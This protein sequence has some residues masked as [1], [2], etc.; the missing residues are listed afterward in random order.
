GLDEI[1]PGDTTAG[2]VVASMARGAAKA[3]VMRGSRRL[4]AKFDLSIPAEG[5][6][7]AEASRLS[8]LGFAPDTFSEEGKCRLVDS[9]TDWKAIAFDAA[10]FS[11]GQSMSKKLSIG[12]NP[13]ARAASGGAAFGFSSGVI[14]ELTKPRQKNEHVDPLAVLGRGLAQ[15]TLD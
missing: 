1:L 15:G 12:S 5:V 4:G 8:D 2:D 14:S 7:M 6:I 3:T 13:I 10:T 9:L 11:I